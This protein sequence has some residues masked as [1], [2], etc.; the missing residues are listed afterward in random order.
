MVL[1]KNQVACLF[2]VSG[3]NMDSKFE[4]RR[5]FRIYTSIKYLE[6]RAL[7]YF[8]VMRPNKTLSYIMDHL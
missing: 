8:G 2:L 1:F 4:F 3:G 5:T 7:R 6:R